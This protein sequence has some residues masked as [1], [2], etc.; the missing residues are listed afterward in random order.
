M[1]MRNALLAHPLVA[2]AIL[3]GL[4]G[5]A[6]ASVPAFKA[7][8]APAFCNTCHEMKPYY[9]A[10]QTGAHKTVDCVDC[11]VDPGTVDHVTHKVTAAKE[12]LVHVTGDPKFPGGNAKVPDERCLKCHGDIGTK[13]TASGFSHARHMKQA[14]CVAC[15]R[16]VGH[17]VTVEMLKDKNLLKPGTE[18]AT[19]KV[20]VQ[21]TGSAEPTASLHV[22]ISCSQCHDLNTAKCSQCH[23]PKHQARGECQTCHVPGAVFVFSHPS[24]KEC[25]TCHKI[26]AKHFPGEC[27]TCHV[28]ATSFK[29]ASFD[30]A[31]TAACRICH[32]APAKHFNGACQTCHNPVTPFKK[33]V[34]KHSSNDCASCHPRPAN[35]R[36]GACATCHSQA[37]VSW[38][39]SHPS[40][41]SC[42]SCH[43][44]PARHHGTQCAGCHS[45]GKAFKSATFRHLGGLNCAQC[46]KATH[47]SYPVSCGSC[48]R[49]PGASWAHVHPS[50]TSCASCHKPP[51]SHYG[52]S[53]ASC[54]SPSRAWASATLRH[55]SVRNH[56]YRSFAC[57]K[58]LPN[59]Y[60]SHYCS[61]HQG[62]KPPSD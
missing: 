41:K 6:S 59:G 42:G 54:H 11:H 24:S 55:P 17:K 14:A 50:S 36:S 52:T 43:K 30:H 4:V 49:K 53:C 33:T 51:A 46:H 56:T 12:L 47:R 40:S 22:K 13:K 15:H 19:T 48:H 21:T 26:P 29:T 18:I 9:E 28:P 16:G 5:V 35:R 57:T 7:S 20:S 23:R 61:C 38:A 25:S 62:G 1:R 32:T 58:C 3:L 8:E 27:G 44:A 60:S 10:W 31:T 37:G 34:Y 2:L 39:F 45:A